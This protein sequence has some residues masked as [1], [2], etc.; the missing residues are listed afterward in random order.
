VSR[1][2][3]L[4]RREMNF[5][6]VMSSLLKQARARANRLQP[7]SHTSRMIHHPAR[8]RLSSDCQRQ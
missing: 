1:L 8:R 4:L 2:F 7:V 3:G 6:A 5:A